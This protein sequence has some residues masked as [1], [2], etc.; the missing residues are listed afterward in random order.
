MPELWRDI[1]DPGFFYKPNPAPADNTRVTYKT[2][3]VPEPKKEPPPIEV[4]LSEGKF[5]PP[6]GGL[7]FNDKCKARV[8]VEYLRETSLKKITFNLFCTYNDNTEQMKP[9][10][11]GFENNGV[12]EAE[13][14]LFYPEDYKQ[15]DKADFFFKASHRR[16]EKVIDSEKLTVP[17]Q[18]KT[19]WIPLIT[20]SNEYSKVTAYNLA[21]LANLAYDNQDNII[22]YFDK[23]RSHSE[24]KFRSQKILSSPF[25]VDCDSEN[26]FII[27]DDKK[28]I[29]DIKETDTQGFIAIN[30]E[31]IL[32]SMRG[33]SD[34]ADALSDANA[35][36][37]PYSFGPG[38]MHEGFYKAFQSCKEMLDKYLKRNLGNKEVIITGHSLGGAIATIIAAYIRAEKKWANLI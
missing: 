3:P 15:G 17:T 23:L 12:A 36:H 10:K 4:K 32:I 5:L 21:Q 29:I 35:R 11:E 14:Q 1:N 25:F 20:F 24:R 33:T 30:K 7:K 2:D 6:S 38:H 31:Q 26:C 8:K 19:G 22:N 28:D 13:F 27:Q 18:T 9:D 37:V 34:W 16:G